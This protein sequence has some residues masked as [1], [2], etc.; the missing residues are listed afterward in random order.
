MKAMLRTAGLLAVAF[1][2]PACGDGGGGSGSGGSVVGGEPDMVE[3]GFYASSGSAS[4]PDPARAGQ[5]GAAGTVDLKA[6]AGIAFGPP[7]DAPVPPAPPGAPAGG[8]V[9]TDADLAADVHDA[10][11]LSIT[12]AL[13]TSGG[14]SVRA[15]R[16][17]GD[18]VVTGS[19]GAAPPQGL[20]LEAGGTLYVSG[21]LRTVS[22][23]ITLVGSV[24]VV[25]GTVD[26]SGDPRSGAG[27]VTIRSTSS[28]PLILAGATLLAEGGTGSS[29][30]RG[31]DILLASGGGIQADAAVS[32]RGGSGVDGENA[33]AGAGGR[34]TIRGAGD[35]DLLGRWNA[36]GGFAQA[37]GEGARGGPGGS[38]DLEAGWAPVRIAA[39]VDVRGGGAEASGTGSGFVS[40]AGGAIRVGSTA[41]AQR[42]ALAFGRIEA[43]GG[44]AD[45]QGGAGGRCDFFAN[46]GDIAFGGTADL[47]G[48]DADASPGAGGSLRLW[49]DVGGGTVSWSGA[50]VS[51][52]GNAR[53]AGVDAPGGAGGNVDVWAF[54]LAGNVTLLGS[55]SVDLTGGASTGT[56][57]AGGGGEMRSV[58]SE[59]AVSFS[60]SVVARGGDAA[61]AG[62]G[63]RGGLL[64]IV[65]DDNGNG[66]G[67]DLTLQPDF[68]ADLSGGNGVVG[69]HARHDLT[70]SASTN[71]LVT[72]C[73]LDSDSAP[74][75]QHNAGGVIRQFG[76]IRARGGANDGWGGDV[77]THGKGHDGNRDPLPGNLDLEGH[78]S[79][80]TGDFISD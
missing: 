12:G 24:V 15:I 26:S 21:A 59:G 51:R 58:S 7:A 16:A 29:G 75:G 36:R 9:L 37:S 28:H 60:G 53:Q 47:S 66:T 18:L 44:A 19:L 64:H 42:I 34:I 56:G 25:T 38:F 76:L 78:G 72:A 33:T 35:V 45:L 67:G 62:E 74:Q 3:N 77:A 27:A 80:R 46:G 57:K 55:A 69:G 68:V 49:C 2:V 5:A 22:A 73:I 39:V 14:G 10:G 30:G 20:H 8:R 6:A 4:H 31:G 23:G 40:G 61:G 50:Y 65:T 17:G 63:G 71:P 11:S 43:R 48:G 13:T 54:G 32:A 41:Q 1:W 70:T 52:G 79:G